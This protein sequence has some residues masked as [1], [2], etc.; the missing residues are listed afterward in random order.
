MLPKYGF[1][2]ICLAM[3]KEHSATGW[4]ICVIA[5]LRRFE[6]QFAFRRVFLSALVS[7]FQATR[8]K[9]RSFRVKNIFSCP[10]DTTHTSIVRSVMGSFAHFAVCCAISSG[11]RD[12]VYNILK[13]QFFVKI[14]GRIWHTY[15]LRQIRSIQSIDVQLI[16]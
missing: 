4:S 5:V 6:T 11:T 15:T 7:T 9:S 3:W 12:D 16:Q 1:P 10:Q 14:S 8:D 2:L 13:S